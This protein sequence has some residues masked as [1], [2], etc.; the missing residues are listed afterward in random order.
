MKKNLV[1]HSNRSSHLQQRMP[2]AFINI[3]HQCYNKNVDIYLKPMIEENDIRFHENMVSTIM[4]RDLILHCSMHKWVKY[5]FWLSSAQPYFRIWCLNEHKKVL[6]LSS[7]Q[8]GHRPLLKSV[9]RH[10]PLSYFVWT[11]IQFKH[12]FCRIIR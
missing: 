3:A 9:Q 11:W 7:S 6:F 1:E 5:F 2:V 4:N 8:P 10:S 12:H